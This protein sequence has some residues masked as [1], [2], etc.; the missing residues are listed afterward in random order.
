MQHFLGRF[1]TGGNITLFL[2]PMGSGKT[3][4]LM[5]KYLGVRSLFMRELSKRKE[6]DDSEISD[7]PDSRI[8]RAPVM[9]CH[10]D[11][12]FVRDNIG[13]GE[14]DEKTG[15]CRKFIFCRDKKFSDK[16]KILTRVIPRLSYISW[17]R[18]CH[19][20]IDDAQF[21]PPGDLKSFCELAVSRD[22]DITMTALNSTYRN[23]M[24]SSVVMILPICDSIL[25]FKATCAKCGMNDAIVNVR[26]SE[27]TTL[28]VSDPEK[29][30]T[31]CLHCHLIRGG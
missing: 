17:K 6:G 1:P 18:Q 30:E 21:F 15:E 12:V 7:P 5:K 20:F 11:S 23:E 4:K 29:Y 2:G 8:S 19:F 3:K 13:G 26:K 16:T 27:E 24:W 31:I 28:L 10:D 9:I 25:F 14:E 22:C